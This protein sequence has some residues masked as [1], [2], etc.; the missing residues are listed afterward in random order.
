M[1]KH[2]TAW[3][4]LL[5]S[6]VSLPAGAETVLKAGH[7]LSANSQF[8]VIV[9]TMNEE[10]AKRTN[11]K[12]RVENYPA[13]A[14][15]AGPAMLEATG[16]GTQEIIISSSGG[17]LSKFNPEA[18]ILDLVGLIQSPE[19]ADAVLDGPIGQ[20]LLDSFAKYNIK[21][22]AWGENG[23]RHLTSA[24]KPISGP[25]DL[26]GV[27]IRLSESEI[28]KDAFETLKA[29]VI[30]APWAQ[31][32]Q[33][34]KDGRAD[35]QENPI[36]TILDGKLQDVQKNLTVSGHTYAAALIGINLDVFNDLSPDEQKTFVEAARKG[37]QASRKFVRDQEKDGIE[38]LKAAGMQITTTFDRAAFVKALDPFYQ[39]YAK[40]YSAE[41]IDQVKAAA[42]K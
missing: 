42:P 41:L 31:V 14:L 30:F 21:G 19:H 26:E 29:K 2:L 38:K 35:A 7:V 18:G 9:T 22:L 11:G 15:G 33:I 5:A 6:A 24:N 1:T 4:A 39:K 13:S 8:S 25:K 12:F 37:A 10:I 17:A 27:T 3:V 16:L 34:L 28:Y 36:V 40:I 20:K 23:F 32:Y